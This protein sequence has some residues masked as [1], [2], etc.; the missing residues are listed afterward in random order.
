MPL[1]SLHPR[2]LTTLFAEVETYS[3]GQPEAFVGTA[4][5]VLGRANAA[6]FA[7]YAHQYYDALGA[8]RERY[9]AGP[10]GNP[11]AEAQAQRLRE[12][13]EGVKQITASIRLLGREGFQLAD[14]RTYA[15]V[16]ALHNH[17]VFAAGG[18]LVGSHAYGILLNRMGIRGASYSTEDVDVAR[19]ERLAFASPPAASFVEMI[20][21][22]GID[23]IE[24]PQLDARQPPTSFRQKG[25]ATFQIDLLA[26]GRGEELGIARVPELDA[27]A[28]TLPFLGYLLKETQVSVLLAREG[29]CAVRVPTPERFAV[30]KLIVAARRSGRNAKSL[31]DRSQAAVLCAALAETHPGAL[32]L[33]LQGVARSA[34]KDVR[35]SLTAMRRD[36]EEQAPRAWE[37][38][39]SF[40]R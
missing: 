4:G 17:G 8:K 40:A 2:S 37:E 26:P 7:F 12:R 36:L 19:G 23:F 28:L 25:R 21:D 13:I 27:H 24:V 3:A 35:A 38:L 6:G 39:S 11:D 31:K 10:A 14:S 34:R 20:R 5:T 30:H 29:C 33:A 22:S 1:F 9:L 18:V 15:T 16:A 32:E